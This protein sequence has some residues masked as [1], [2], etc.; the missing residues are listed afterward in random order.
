MSIKGTVM[1]MIADVFQKYS[2]NFAFQVFII[3]Q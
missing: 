3:W 2:E 1:Q